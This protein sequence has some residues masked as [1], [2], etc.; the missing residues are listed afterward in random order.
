MSLTKKDGKTICEFIKDNDFDLLDSRE[1]YQNIAD[2][3]NDFEIKDFRFIL[4]SDIDSIMIEDLKND[5]YIL[6]CFQAW[7]ISDITGIGYEAVK[8]IQDAEA[9]EA[10]GKL[11]ISMGKIEELQEQYVSMDGYG[12]HFAQYDGETDED[13]LFIST[14]YYA[15]RVN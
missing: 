5:E 4:E 15:F 13:L 3:I 8:A 14:G 2:N 7:F 10:L 1:L 6:G 12:H 9:F 11:I